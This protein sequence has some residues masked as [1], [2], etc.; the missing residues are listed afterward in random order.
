MVPARFRAS[1][2]NFL[3]IAP[4]FQDRNQLPDGRF[5]FADDDAVNG[6]MKKILRGKRGVMAADKKP[7][8]FDSR[9]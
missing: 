5:P 8:R 6:R 9:L 3:K 2:G 4:L 7:E 1:P